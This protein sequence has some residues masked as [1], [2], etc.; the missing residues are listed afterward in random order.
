MVSNNRSLANDSGIQGTLADIGTHISFG[1]AAGD[2]MISQE[3]RK[4]DRRTTA[5]LRGS[6]SHGDE[7]A[8]V[9]STGATEKR[10]ENRAGQV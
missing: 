7:E 9:R 6:L 8:E 1:Q 5:R 3:N 4:K 10:E 2:S